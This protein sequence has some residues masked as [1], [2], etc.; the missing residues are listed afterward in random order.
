MERILVAIDGS[1]S[2]HEAL[3][4]ALDLAAEQGTPVTIAH[5][6]DASNGGVLPDAKDDDALQEALELARHA[7]VEPELTLLH[8]DAAAELAKLAEEIDADLVIVGSRGLGRAS[9]SLLGSVSRS[10]LEAC[11]RPVMVVR[12]RRTSS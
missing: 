3:H 4:V 12:G 1:S 2:A 10:T 7:E 11:K 9:A 5:V 8:G 6:V